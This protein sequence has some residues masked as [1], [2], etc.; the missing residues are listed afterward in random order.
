[1]NAAHKGDRCPIH[2]CP[3]KLTMHDG[4]SLVCSALPHH[5]VVDLDYT[6]QERSQKAKER[7]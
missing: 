5:R 2:G 1:V 3:G 7:F 6:A 4:P